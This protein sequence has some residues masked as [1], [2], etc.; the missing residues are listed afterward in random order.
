MN[1]ENVQNSPEVQKKSKINPE[2]VQNKSDNG[3]FIN[4]R[5]CVKHISYGRISD[6]RRI[7]FG[8]KKNI[9]C[10][11]MNVEHQ[12]WMILVLSIGRCMTDFSLLLNGTTVI[13][14]SKTEH[15]II[16]NYRS[17]IHSVEYCKRCYLD[18]RLSGRI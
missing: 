6:I 15:N 10:P 4:I 13:D 2:D 14:I 5:S 11:K 3:Y 17:R 18:Y 9:R 12:H 7:F 16:K 1:S 8:S